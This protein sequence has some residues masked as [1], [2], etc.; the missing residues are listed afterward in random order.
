MITKTGSNPK[1]WE[2]ELISYDTDI[3]WKITQQQ[4]GMNYW[5]TQVG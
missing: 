5:Y 1:D 4:I 3:Q 2:N